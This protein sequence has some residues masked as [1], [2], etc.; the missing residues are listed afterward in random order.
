M[1]MEAA[2]FL[3]GRGIVNSIVT[4]FG[5]DS[6]DVVSPDQLPAE[7]VEF[8]RRLS[9]HYFKDDA[10][11]AK[12]KAGF[13]NQKTRN[14]IDVGLVNYEMLNSFAN[15]GN[16]FKF[17]DA[18]GAMAGSEDLKKIMGQFTVKMVEEDGV[19]GYRFY[20]KYDFKNSEAYFA[21]VFPDILQAAKDDGYDTSST[22]GAIN[23]TAKS[24]ARNLGKNPEGFTQTMTAIGHPVSRL[25]ADWFINEDMDEEDKVKF[26]F[27]IPADKQAEVLASGSVNPVEYPESMPT[28]R[29]E[30]LETASAVLP[31][32]PM[33]NDRASVF[34]EFMNFIIPKAEASTIKPVAE[35]KP[36]TFGQTFAKARADGL[37][38]FEFTNKEGKTGMYT[39]EVAQ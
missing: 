9:N 5:G 32:G 7:S 19:K 39:T 27:F 28:A 18:S 26:D 33:D 1:T 15:L 13:K 29:P 24:I 14:A 12:R 6:M 34:E 10:T 8:L 22:L 36:L 16:M 4:A 35:T 37:K 11:R 30:N 17:K 2:K 38:Q 31:N 20:D 25:L 23:M 21:G 3:Y